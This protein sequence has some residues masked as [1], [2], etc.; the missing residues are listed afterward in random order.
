MVDGVVF[1]SVRFDQSMITLLKIPYLVELS[2]HYMTD[3]VTNARA[4]DQVY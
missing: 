1:G 3:Y 2:N 4:C